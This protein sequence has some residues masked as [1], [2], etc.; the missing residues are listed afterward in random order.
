MKLQ[1]FNI[2]TLSMLFV[3]TLSMHGME[4]ENNE[5]HPLLHLPIEIQQQIVFPGYTNDIAIH[6]EKMDELREVAKTFF[7]FN[8]LSKDFNQHFKL[9]WQN[10]ELAKKNEMLQNVLGRV[11]WFGYKEYRMVPLVLVYSGADVDIKSKIHD[12]FLCEAVCKNDETAVTM[13]LAHGADPYQV[14]NDNGKPICFYALTVVMAEL[15]LKK[16]DKDKLLNRYSGFC[17]L[18][19]PEQSSEIMTVWFDYGVNPRHIYAGS[20]DDCLWHCLVRSLYWYGNTMQNI[21]VK[22]ELLLQRIPDMISTIN[23]CGETPLDMAI[24]ADRHNNCCLHDA[25]KELIA[26]FRKHGAK[27][28]QELEEENK[29]LITQQ[30]TH[31]TTKF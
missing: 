19:H 18:L 5:L 21:R 28:A 24:R 15:F 29:Q 9:P 22:S 17:D 31:E 8:I 23:A 27:T 25:H 2:I 7:I 10:L 20:N 4:Q 14:D 6:R 16:F 13:L 26:F 12:T 30:E 11:K 1:N 3:I